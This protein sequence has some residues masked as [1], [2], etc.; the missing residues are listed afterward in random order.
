[1]AQVRG[2]KVITQ[3]AASQVVIA[4]R[5]LGVSGIPR[6]YE[7]VYEVLNGSNPELVSEFNALGPNPPQDK[8]DE[9]GAKFFAE[10]HGTAVV[11]GAQDKI[12]A[13][14]EGMLRLLRNEQTSLESYGKLLG[15]TYNRINSKSAASADILHNIVGMLSNATG[16]TMDRGKSVAASMKESADEM[17]RVREELDEY[18]RM[19]NTD[20][21]TKLSNRRAFDEVLSSIYDRPREAMYY[22]LVLSDI[23][24]FK[25]INDT[26][27]HPVGDR[28]LM[29]IA[30]VIRANLRKDVFV[31][32]AGGEEFAIVISGTDEGSTVEITERIRAAIEATPLK[33]Q[34]TG[35][36]YGP[37]TM[38]F[39]IAMASD[40]NDPADLYNKVD[41]ALYSAKASG[42]NKVVMYHEGLQDVTN[43]NRVMYHK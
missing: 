1:M 4:M 13:E 17:A 22:A 18:K 31:S 12:I 37:V 28:V 21:L 34:K 15:E 2:N 38:S 33:N 23:D 24:H 20:P 9:I 8:L 41:L 35:M 43:G 40:A 26:W 30:K 6:N 27:G 36:D 42:R 3:D 32:R 5:R 39:G 10:H 25:K 19:A 14:L 7:L 16:D 11:S 29:V